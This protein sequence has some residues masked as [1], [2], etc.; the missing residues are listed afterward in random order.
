[1]REGTR[2]PAPVTMIFVEPKIPGSKRGTEPSV[3]VV[4]PCHNEAPSIADV[5]RDFRRALPQAIIVVADN[6]ST[7][8][9]ANIAKREGAFV[10]PEVRL[11]KGRAV[12]RLFADVDADIYVLVRTGTGVRS[13]RGTTDGSD[14]R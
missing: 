3:A 1:M 4:I 12:R 7:D 8:D 2:S 10:I 14:G 9:T 5:I 6:A 13:R 11:G